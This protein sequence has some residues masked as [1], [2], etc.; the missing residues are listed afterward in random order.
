MVII[1]G[2]T[3]NSVNTRPK[4]SEN[5]TLTCNSFRL[6]TTRPD[7]FVTYSKSGLLETT[8]QEIKL[9]PK[10]LPSGNFN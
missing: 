1:L 7:W 8:D 3:V 4:E 6:G 9:D 5:V 2:V 10:A